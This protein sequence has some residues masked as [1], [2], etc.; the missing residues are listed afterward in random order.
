MNK[1]YTIIFAALLFTTSAF[2]QS[3]CETTREEKGYPMHYCA[4]YEDNTRL[5]ALPIDTTIT[6]SVWFKSTLKV[7]I[8]SGM[9]A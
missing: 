8:N 9:T 5:N 6:D 3:A 1:F 2:A 7:F 4:C